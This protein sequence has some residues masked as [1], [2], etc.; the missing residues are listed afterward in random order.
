MTPKEGGH[1]VVHAEDPRK[2]GRSDPRPALL[3]I[4]V[5]GSVGLFARRIN[6]E[7]N[8]NGPSTHDARSRAALTPSTFHFG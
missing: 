7:S 1:D 2:S 8:Q 4:H 5:R 6:G 3:T